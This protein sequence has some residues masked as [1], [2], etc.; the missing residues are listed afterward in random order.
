VQVVGSA[1]SFAQ[2]V[3]VQLLLMLQQL[4]PKLAQSAPV[5]QRPDE[6]V[7]CPEMQMPLEQV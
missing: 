3:P 1:H 4:N 5:L 6:Q 2:P 7:V